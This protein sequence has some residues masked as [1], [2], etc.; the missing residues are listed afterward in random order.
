MATADELLARLPAKSGGKSADDLLARLPPKGQESNPLMDAA[1]EGMSSAVNTINLPYKLG[2]TFNRGA[3]EAGG[4]VAEYLGG[5]MNNNVAPALAGMATTILA[6]PLSYIPT[7]PKVNFKLGASTGKPGY[8]ARIKQMRTG[9]EAGDFE[10]LRRDP[11]AFFNTTAR[12]EAGKAVGTAKEAAG[13][14]TGVTRDI[15]SLTPENISKARNLQGTANKAQDAVIEKLEVSNL[16]VAQAGSKTGKPHA[17]FAYTDDFGPGG[18][19]RNIY[20]VFGDPENPIVK[21]RGWGSS[22][23]KEDLDKLGIPVTGRQAGSEKYLAIDPNEA[24]TA[25][26]GINKRLSKLEHTEGRGSPSFQQ[27]SAIKKH[28]QGILEQVAPG[29]KEANKDFSRVALRDKFMEPFPVNQSGT[30]S[31]IDAW[32]FGPGAAGV[33]ALVGGPIGAVGALGAKMA[34]RS[35]FVAGLGTATRGLADKAIDPILSRIAN[36]PL[37]RRIAIAKLSSKGQQLLGQ[38]EER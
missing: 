4:N 6:N 25:L 17:V 38:R 19:K 26:E 7:G 31:K 12:A 2:E 5:K 21:Q 33:G 34:A 1:R 24:S 22:V 10:R 36:N 20:N 14:N 8:T 11:T 27:W 9:V 35:P 30:M 32:G 28:F 13:I 16:P 3:E 37:L 15:K 29:V 23:A 18:T